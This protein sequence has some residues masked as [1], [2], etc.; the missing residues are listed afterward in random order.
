MTAKRLTADER[1]VQIL[2]QAWH[3]FAK[4]GY[5]GS[6]TR[7]I[8][9]ECGVTE[10]VVFSHFPTK[11]ALYMATC[12]H[13]YQGVHKDWQEI[14]ASQLN[15]ADSLKGIIRVEVGRMSE[16]VQLCQMITHGMSASI[17]DDYVGTTVRPWMDDKHRIV[18]GVIKQGIE[19]GSLHNDLDPDCTALIFRG[20]IWVHIINMACDLKVR[21][22]KGYPFRMF[23]CPLRNIGA[24]GPDENF[25]VSQ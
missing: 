8:A 17:S 4:F 13:G 3:V 7:D 25:T 1:R 22:S 10:A 14:F 18:S 12:D 11:L 19:D 15:G 6:K 24:L 2:E 9:S 5:H 21:H 23:E 16:N 20:L